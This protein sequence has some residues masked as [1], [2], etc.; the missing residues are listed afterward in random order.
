[1]DSHAGGV[2]GPAMPTDPHE[3][4]DDLRRAVDDYIERTKHIPDDTT[5]QGSIMRR[6]LEDH[7][8]LYRLG[9]LA[10][11]FDLNP[12]AFAE[13]D[14]VRC[15]VDDLARAGLLYTVGDGDY[16]ILPSAPALYFHALPVYL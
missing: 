6:V 14:A 5:L 2:Y 8:N 4:P 12:D 13:L 3:L 15:G 11:S 1:M 10:R 7:P 16:L 9:D